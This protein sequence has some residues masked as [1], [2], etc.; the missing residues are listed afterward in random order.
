[1]PSRNFSRAWRPGLNSARLP[2]RHWLTDRGSLTQRLKAR[3]VGFRVRPMRQGFD[4]P[5]EDERGYFSLRHGELALVREVYLLCGETPLVF[6][7]SVLSARDLEGVWNAVSRQGARPLGEALFSDPRVSRTPLEYC[8]LGRHHTLHAR[9]CDLLAEHPIRLWARRS[10][11]TL[12]SR[13]L[14]VTEV[15]LPP[16]LEL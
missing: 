15:F 9:A 14:L 7:H 8:Q 3:C 16:V 11:F 10:L 2:Y 6:A 1:M 4:R 13:P 5:L 12:R